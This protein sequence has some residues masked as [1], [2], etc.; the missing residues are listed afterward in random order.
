MAVL[1]TAIAIV[2][3]FGLS[4]GQM[5]IKDW[6]VEPTV[7]VSRQQRIHRLTQ[8]KEQFEGKRA[9]GA[10]C[11]AVTR[12]DGHVEKGRLVFATTNSV[13]LYDPS[14]VLARRIPTE[15]AVVESIDAL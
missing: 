1:S 15:G 4:A 3:I 9:R 7:C 8:P 5:H 14:K 10:D 12:S 13:V 11:V 2:P 6:V